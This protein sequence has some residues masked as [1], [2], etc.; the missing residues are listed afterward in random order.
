M[1]ALLRWKFQVQDLLHE[2]EVLPVS[3]AHLIA[4][5]GWAYAKGLK[6][7]DPYPPNYTSLISPI[8][9]MGLGHA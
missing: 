4:R 8:C 6:G 1:K 9:C 5:M 7:T 3:L 2:S